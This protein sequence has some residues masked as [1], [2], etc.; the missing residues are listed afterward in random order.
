M[1]SLKDFVIILDDD[2][3]NFD[4]GNK[5]NKEWIIRYEANNKE[6]LQRKKSFDGNPKFVPQ[7]EFDMHLEERTSLTH[8]H[9]P[10]GVPHPG[11]IYRVERRS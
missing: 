11:A 9:D 10:N 2:M 3:N 8:T 7:V 5:N 4:N 1:S 6:V